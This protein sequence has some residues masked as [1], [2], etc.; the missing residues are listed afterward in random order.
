MHTLQRLSKPSGGFGVTFV[1]QYC[2][3]HAGVA[4]PL[5]LCLT[6]S[7]DA[8]CSGKGMTVVRQPALC[9]LRQSLKGPRA[10]LMAKGMSLRWVAH[11]RVWAA[12]SRVWAVPFHFSMP[13]TL[14][15]YD[16]HILA[17]TLTISELKTYLQQHL[18]SSLPLSVTD[19]NLQ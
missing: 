18:C 2:P 6:L 17:L 8:G 11:S 19:K 7:P 3:C 12:H 5:Y 15:K 13:T 4:G 1:H 9:R 16:V 14:T 10:R